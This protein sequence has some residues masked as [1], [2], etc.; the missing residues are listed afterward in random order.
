MQN[1][2][3]VFEPVH[4]PHVGVGIHSFLA[5]CQSEPPQDVCCVQEELHLRHLVSHTASGSDAVRPVAFRSMERAFELAL[6]R[7]QM[8]VWPEGLRVKVMLG[9]IVQA[10]DGRYDHGAFGHGVALDLCM[11]CSDVRQ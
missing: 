2:F 1:A 6:L 10:V 4:Y 5:G 3:K 9:V 8:S 11:F 7:A